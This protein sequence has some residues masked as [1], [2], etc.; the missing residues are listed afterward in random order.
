MKKLI[1]AACATSLFSGAA[2]AGP[3]HKH[4]R[5]HE[6]ATRHYDQH[7]EHRAHKQNFHK[8]LFNFALFVGAALAIDAALDDHNDHYDK[9]A[10]PHRPHQ[11][12]PTPKPYA[13]GA[14]INARQDRQARRIKQGVRSGELVR[15]EAKQLRRQQRR[16][17]DLE[18]EF[19]ADGRFSKKER[20]IIQAKLDKA[21]DRI[22]ELKHNHRSRG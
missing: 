6:Q 2:L 4:G 17:A 5:T 1:I 19:R 8:D 14:S 18:H 21:S 15:K 22:Y 13:G 16:I 10:K 20:R 12:K 7:R 3:N 11:A 9:P